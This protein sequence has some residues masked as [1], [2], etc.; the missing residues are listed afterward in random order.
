MGQIRFGEGFNTNVVAGGT[1]PL[2]E[3]LA[4]TIA[5]GVNFA[6]PTRPTAIRVSALIPATSFRPMPRS[7]TSK[8]A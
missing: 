5:G 2:D 4:L 6:A 3:T 8:A 1:I 7:S